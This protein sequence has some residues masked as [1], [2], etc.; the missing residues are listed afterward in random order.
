MRTPSVSPVD[1]PCDF[2]IDEMF[3]STTDKKGIIRSGNAVFARVSG[4]PM[5][6]LVGQ[7]HNIIR[8]PDMPRVVF[9]LL[10]DFLGRNLPVVALVK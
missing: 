10:W 4:Y 3:F 8:H 9:R 7:P 1:L 5:A 6:E 2:L